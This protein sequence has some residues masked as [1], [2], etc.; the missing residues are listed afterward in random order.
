METNN[1][2]TKKLNEAL[3]KFGSLEK[4]IANME[5]TKLTLE[6]QT[7]QLKTDKNRLL[8]EK[9]KLAGQNKELDIKVQNSQNQLQSIEHKINEFYYQFLLF[10]GFLA[11]VTG[12]PSVDK[13]IEYLIAIFQKLKEPGWIFIKKADDLKSFFIKQ[14]MGDYLKCYRCDYCGTRFLVNKKL[15]NLAL[16]NSYH[17]PACGYSFR[18]K[19]DDSFLKAMVS[20]QQLE[21]TEILAK[22]KEEYDVL[23][24]FKT[25]LETPCE[26]CKKPVKEWDND[27]VKLAIQGVGVGHTACWNSELG[28][29]RQLNKALKEI[30]NQ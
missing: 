25:F 18:I 2:N 10:S 22:V 11:M 15:E 20:K 5:Q 29:L 23:K 12:S 9:D 26:I 24:P 17:C 1:I 7:F 3:T 14:V 28:R 27:N 19:E 8:L 4:A 13:S 21:D 6:K 16:D 30:K